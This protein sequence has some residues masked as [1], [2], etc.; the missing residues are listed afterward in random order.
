MQILWQELRYG[1]RM[2]LKKRGFTVVAVITL[3]LG[4]GANATMFSVINGMLLRPLPF[5]DPER[6]A[7]LD[8]KAL[9][10]GLDTAGLS[11]PDF[12]DW[13]S[14][15]RSFER[16]ALYEEVSFTLSSGN[17]TER[18]ER[19]EGARVTAS[20][21]P[22]LGVEAAQGRYFLEEEDKPGAAPA[23]IIGYGLW[24]RRYGGDPGIIGRAVRIDGVSVT[25]VGVMPA[26]FGFPIKA[27]LWKPLAA[28]FDEKDRGHHFAFGI[29]RL[30]PGVTIEAAGAEIE[31]IAAAIAREHPKTNDGFEGV[32]KPWR[33]AVLEDAGDLLWLLLGAVGFVMLIACANVANLLLTAGASRAGELAIRSAL[34]ASRASLMRQMLI[35]SL[36]L[37]SLGGALGLL[38]ALWGADG[39]TA[40]LPEAMPAW[41]AFSID[42]RVLAFTLGATT[43]T[44]ILC[45][46]A[47]GWQ[48]SK[49]DLM[50]VMK[51][52]ARG[53]AG[54]R[55]QR[56]RSLLVIGEVALA[57]TLLIGA[58]LMMKSFIR[59]RQINIGFK[60]DHV[61][62]AK[63]AL[64]ETQYSAPAQRNNFYR[65]LLERLSAT[66]GVESAALTSSLPL[67][68]EDIF[69][70]GFYAEG[71]PKPRST[72]EVPIALQSVVSPGY[73]RTMGMQLIRGRD[74]ND[75]DIEGKEKVVI[76]DET[77]ARRIF[78][79]EDPIGKRIAF[80]GAMSDPHW[81][82]IIG[83]VGAVR[84][85]GL[86][87]DA[88]M[89]AY[90]TYQQSSSGVMTIV[91]R[92]TGD[93]A[94]LTAALRDE[95]AALDK[96]SPLYAPRLMTEVV[97]TAMWDDKYVGILFGLFAALALCLA[98]VGIYG[99]VSNSVAQ[100]THEIGIRMAL[101]AQT[102]DV[103]RMIFRQGI[104]L[105]ALGAAV[106]L[107]LAA[108]GSRLMESL[109]FN[110]SATDP[111]IF[112][113]LPLT[114][115]AVTLA[116]CWLP[117]RRAAKVDPMVALRFE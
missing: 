84:H 114:L 98:A 102:G 113:F 103:M 16:M 5:K 22:L 39:I 111:V 88:R 83:V 6:L 2:L 74:F 10:A 15:S 112:T 117:A 11:F 38:I 9:K 81:S 67:L 89:Q 70:S 37:A 8:E 12:S 57:M 64:L 96:D 116:A 76:V 45:G 54:L 95:V 14:G 56:L 52:G 31:A 17:A 73:F 109:L 32:V 48:A 23:A 47:P 24:R 59:V 100:R 20:L 50:S 82:T 60:A 19:V 35:E 43:A 77:I 61:M 107:G 90:Q 101:G 55:K 41:M 108:L 110:V 36:L 68:E 86:K 33:D 46:F 66:P 65:Q 106:G 104:M 75:A 25:I 29:G 34:G 21:F 51:D 79:D 18:A 13:R 87:R 91:A 3:G 49:T 28:A 115:L 97:A 105:A 30:K 99:V 40:M 69:G 80:D 85:Y 53:S 93:P 78:A 26:G 1:A 62:T 4:I 72:S 27:E 7:H 92:A 58:G 94:S 42:W 63:V 71:K 44:A